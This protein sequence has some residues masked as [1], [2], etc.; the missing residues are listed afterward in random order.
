[1]PVFYFVLVWTYGKAFFAN[2]Q[3]AKQT[4][5]LLLIITV[6]LHFASLVFRTLTLL[7]PPVTTVF[8]IFTVLAFSIAIIYLFIEIRSQRKETG[9]FILNIAFF[10]QLTSSVFIKNTS[11]VPEILRSQFF[12]AHVICA[13]LGYAAITIAGA[14]SFMYLILYHEMK[15]SRFGTI[16]KKLP[17]LESLERMTMTAIKL[18]VG[19]LGVAICF[20]IVWLHHVYQNA[21]YDD[22]KLIGTVIVWIMYEFL[23]IARKYFGIQ[24][25]K[26]MI[27]SIAGFLFSIFSMT[28]VNIFFSGFHRFY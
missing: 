27:L 19:L 10:F 8:E 2:K 21:H 12:G 18:V 5:T 13:L 11:E 20:G 14:Y 22:P 28:I 16:Y 24:G 15:A 23:V 17:T 1:M 26:V 3:W 6:A 25:R 7:H 4:K 9:Y